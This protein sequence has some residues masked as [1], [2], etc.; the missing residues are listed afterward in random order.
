[1]KL[2]ID[3]IEGKW[4]VAQ[5]PDGNMVELPKILLPKAT[6]GDVIVIDIDADERDKR[7]QAVEELMNELFTD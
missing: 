1:M 6:E 7:Q 2:V 3:R 5:M 4:I